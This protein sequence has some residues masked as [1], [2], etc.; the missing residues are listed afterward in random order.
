MF[1]YSF[2]GYSVDSI[3]LRV[4]ERIGYFYFILNLCVADNLT[5][6]ILTQRHYSTL[7]GWILCHFFLQILKSAA[8]F[9]FF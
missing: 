7:I 9:D 3:A 4:N 6:L 1:P 2:W 5:N 8:G